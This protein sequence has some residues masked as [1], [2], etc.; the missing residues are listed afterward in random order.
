MNINLIRLKNNLEKEIPI[1]ITYSFSKEEL[2]TTEI[3]E[4]N[5]LKIVGTLEKNWN[6]CYGIRYYV[7][8]MCDYFKKDPLSF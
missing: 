5:D 2:E 4:L 7:F 1:D 6:G 3:L 8:I